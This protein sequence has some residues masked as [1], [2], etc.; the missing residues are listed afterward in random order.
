MNPEFDRIVGEES[1]KTL[2][3]ADPEQYPAIYA[4]PEPNESYVYVNKEGKEL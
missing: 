2:L 1:G 4:I 3:Q